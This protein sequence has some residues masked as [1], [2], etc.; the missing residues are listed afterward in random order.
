[1]NFVLQD[2]QGYQGGYVQYL[3]ALVHELVKHHSQDHENCQ[4]VPSARL[5][6]NQTVLVATRLDPVSKISKRP[7]K[8]VL[9]NESESTEGLRFISWQPSNQ[10][11][12][13]RDNGIRS[14]MPLAKKLVDLTPLAADWW[15]EAELFNLE[16]IMQGGMAAQFVLDGSTKNLSIARR[17]E[18][19]ISY[20]YDTEECWL[21]S[22]AR[23]YA[24]TAANRAL[25][26]ECVLMLVN[27]QKFIV[28]CVCAVLSQTGASK[29]A[30]VDITRVCFGNVSE[31]YALRL[32][33]TA[34]FLNQLVDG[35]GFR[36]WGNRASELLLICKATS[37]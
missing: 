20:K 31:E 29:P 8:R 15:K 16:T 34:V 25:T 9:D 14:W 4:F 3:K 30:L 28:L 35:L 33:R 18:T 19:Q 21:L 2:S 6:S 7:Q 1:M 32:W 22:A 11:P 10:P 12:K 27:F 24:E 17:K 13:P 26:V 23:A 37:A 5:S 36:G